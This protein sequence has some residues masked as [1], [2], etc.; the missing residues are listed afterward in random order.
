MRKKIETTS[1]RNFYFFLLISED[2]FT[3]RGARRNLKTQLITIAMGILAPFRGSPREIRFA[4]VRY[5]S[6]TR[7][8]VSSNHAGF[9][10]RDSRMHRKGAVPKLGAAADVQYDRS[11]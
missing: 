7:S 2:L 4:L 6:K 10:Q 8:S 5:P 1:Q 9:F 11:V 3:H